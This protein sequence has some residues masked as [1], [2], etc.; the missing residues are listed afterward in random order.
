MSKDLL[1]SSLPSLAPLSRD[2]PRQLRPRLLRFLTKSPKMPEEYSASSLALSGSLSRK[3]HRLQQYQLQQHHLS[4][5]YQPKSRRLNLLQWLPVLHP[6]LLLSREPRFLAQRS[7]SELLLLLL[8][9]T[10]CKPLRKLPLSSLLPKSVR[11][12]TLPSRW[13]PSS[14]RPPFQARRPP[15][16]LARIPLFPLKSAI[17]VP[18]SKASWAAS[19]VQS[20]KLPQSRTS[21]SVSFPVVWP[22]PHRLC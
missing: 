8:R 4:K 7:K 6:P 21:S 2:C 5:R 22:D 11:S 18:I 12:A 19:A 10:F 16:L 3:Q 13:S 14:Q 20:P 17:S 9:S 1:L 15:L